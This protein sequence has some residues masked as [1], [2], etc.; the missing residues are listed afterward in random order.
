MVRKFKMGAL[1][2][3]DCEWQVG[4][5]AASVVCAKDA[6]GYIVELQKLIEDIKAKKVVL[7]EYTSPLNIIN[8][9]HVTRPNM[10]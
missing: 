1:P 10:E 7:Q 6:M 9:T 3:P 4:C 5:T 8:N 2:P